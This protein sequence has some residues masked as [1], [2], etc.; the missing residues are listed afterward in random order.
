MT[1]NRNHK[2][3][4]VI[5]NIIKV[6]RSF[7][8]LVAELQTMTRNRNHKRGKVI[9]NIIKVQEFFYPCGRVADHD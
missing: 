1:R 6:K 4:K 7:L 2:R 8:I 5:A 9:T 3:G